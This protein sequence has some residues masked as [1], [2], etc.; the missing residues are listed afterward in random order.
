V[1]WVISV[2]FN[3]RNTLPKSGT[4]LLGHPVYIYNSASS[5]LVL[6]P[7]SVYSTTNLK[8]P[9]SLSQFSCHA[10]SFLTP[11]QERHGVMQFVLLVPK[12]CRI[13]PPSRLDTFLP[14]DKISTQRSV[15][16]CTGRPV[17]GAEIQEA[18]RN[19]LGR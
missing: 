3:I 10:V 19:L 11:T 6:L 16:L 7:Y 12:V 18:Y 2:Y 15:M 1:I 9:S 4:F 14:R 17:T 13:V 8:I 5:S